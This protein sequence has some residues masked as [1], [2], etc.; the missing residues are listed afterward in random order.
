MTPIDLRLPRGSEAKVIYNSLY[1][2]DAAS[3][4]TQDVL[5]LE[6]GNGVFIDVGW[7]PD[8]DPAGSYRINVYREQWD[9]QLRKPIRTRDPHKVAEQVQK[10]AAR[11]GKVR[12]NVKVAKQSKT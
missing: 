4:R 11:Y 7:Y 8:R 6:L 3:H 5:F 9:N 2:A 12:R 10:L 1:A